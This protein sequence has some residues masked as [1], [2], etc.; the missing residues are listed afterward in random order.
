MDTEL[1]RLN[2][3]VKMFDSTLVGRR[4]FHGV[5]QVCQL[6]RSWERVETFDEPIF[7]AKDT[8][9]H[10]FSLTDNWSMNGVP[11][12][13]GWVPLYHKMREIS[14]ERQEERFRE[15]E[16]MEEENRQRRDRETFNQC[17]AMADEAHGVIKETFKD[18]NTSN[19]D[20]SKDPRRKKDRSIKWQ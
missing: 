9:V 2:K 4:S 17:E 10:V 20:M 19:M 15:F 11:V 6:I 7:V 18:V 1:A 14:L 13:W 8:P 5:L 3:L 12:S 16:A